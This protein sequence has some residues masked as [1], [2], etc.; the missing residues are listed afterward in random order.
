M[1]EEREEEREERG[2]WIMGPT[3][4][5]DVTLALNGHFSTV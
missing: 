3:C 1:R 2:E 4:H 5:M